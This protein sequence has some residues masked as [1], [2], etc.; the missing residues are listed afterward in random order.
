MIITVDL[1]DIL[2]FVFIV[3]WIVFIVWGAKGRK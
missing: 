2:S 1:F 3:S